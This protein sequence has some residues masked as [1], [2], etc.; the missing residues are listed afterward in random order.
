MVTPNTKLVRYEINF[1]RVLERRLKL[2][3]SEGK[4]FADGEEIFVA[5]GLKVGLFEN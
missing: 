1:S 2:G 3:I 5:K 4:V